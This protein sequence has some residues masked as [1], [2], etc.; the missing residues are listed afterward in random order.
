MQ[1]PDYE[2]GDAL[3]SLAGQVSSEGPKVL[4]GRLTLDELR[5]VQA[6]RQGFRWANGVVLVPT[7]AALARRGVLEPVPGSDGWTT[8]E[9]LLERGGSGD[10]RLLGTLWGGLKLLALQG[11][12]ELEGHDSDSRFRPTRRG[13]AAGR[14][15]ARH[16]QV[17]DA[18]PRW[19]EALSDPLALRSG[20]GPD[21]S[22][23][24]L[25]DMASLH[26]R[27][28]G[29]REGAEAEEPALV[30]ELVEALDGLLV[31][32]LLVAVDMPQYRLEASG[33]R[34]CGPSPFARLAA[35][36]GRLGDL[37]DARFAKAAESVFASAGI[38]SPDRNALTE[39]GEW[40]RSVA[41]PFCGLGVSYLRSY[42]RVDELMFVNPDPLG[43]DRDSHVDR[44]VNIYASAGA[45]SGPLSR[46]LLEKG[47]RAI[48]DRP[49]EEQPA[50]VAD[51]GCGDGSGL[52]RMVRY[53]VE[54]TE[55][56]RNLDRY[57]LVAVGADYNESARL[58]AA[59]TLS[60]L[61]GVPGVS[62][63]VLHADISDPVGYDAAIRSAGLS[64]A[65]PE[66]EDVVGAADLVHSFM[67]LL[68]N[69]RLAVRDDAEAEAVFLEAGCPAGS[70]REAFGV[71]FAGPDGLV[72]GFQ[73]AA[74]LLA[75]LHRWRPFLGSGMLVLEGHSPS[76]QAGGDLSPGD[77]PHVLNWGMHFPSRQYM[78]PFI[79]FTRVLDIA[80]FSPAGGIH[81][82]VYPEGLRGPD[83]KG[84]T[85]FFSIGWFK[86]T[87]RRSWG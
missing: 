14:L 48:F 62:W 67:F 36:E 22:L 56:G 35:G 20:S 52:L 63:R 64:R 16:R 19:A 38:L 4:S 61:D 85:R 58:V 49:L 6:L 25:S 69:R 78:M 47:V 50:G 59:T 18:V 83:V 45:G 15:H 79:E 65:R 86:P 40:L 73:A 39:W 10:R 57:P 2:D 68:H 75:M 72:S 44:V 21:G 13:I 26:G 7:F 55:R 71:S 84:P 8:L 28:W 51:M 27:E 1:F 87:A 11:L 70:E 81:G 29:F 32:S 80:G 82:S 23:A 66:G 17:F 43:I 30:E 34:P 74:D 53:I 42:A 5:K 41:A 31:G 33:L 54:H 9:A 46:T 60:A 24:C 37:T 76:P 3:L 77:L 12:V